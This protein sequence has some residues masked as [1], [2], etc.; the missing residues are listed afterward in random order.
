MAPDWSKRS[1]MQYAYQKVM[2]I[3]PDAIKEIESDR[4]LFRVVYESKHEKPNGVS[5]I[6]ELYAYNI[7]MMHHMVPKF[8]DIPKHLKFKFL[9]SLGEHQRIFS[10]QLSFE[11]TPDNYTAFQKALEEEIKKGD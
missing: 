4:E 5:N 7:E 2:G 6:D 1:D 8:P 11:M 3:H 9:M 10:S